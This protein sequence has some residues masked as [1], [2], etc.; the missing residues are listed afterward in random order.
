VVLFQEPRRAYP[1]RDDSS[2]PGG[3]GCSNR[4]H[5]AEV[6]QGAGFRL[7]NVTDAA[8]TLQIADAD[9]LVLYL[10]AADKD[11][12]VAGGLAKN[13]QQSDVLT[14]LTPQALDATGAAAAAS[15][16]GVFGTAVGRSPFTIT[17][18]NDATVGDIGTLD[19]YVE[20]G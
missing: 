4:H 15:E 7:S 2:K 9:S 20:R 11:Y 5:A 10:D 19:L 6:R 8:T 13:L 1:H 3:V 14:G 17:R 16:T 12:H 18:S